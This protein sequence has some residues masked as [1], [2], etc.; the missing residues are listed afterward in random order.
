MD[1][2]GIS[3][4]SPGKKA[5]A[6]LFFLLFLAAGDYVLAAQPSHGAAPA[7]V[8]KLI[9][10][11]VQDP[12]YIVK[13]KDGR[14]GGLNVEIWKSIARDLN[15]D[16]EFRETTFGESL[17]HLKEGTIDISIESYFLLAERQKQI[18]YSIP[19]GN[20]RLALATLPNKIP[21]PWWAAVMILFSWATLKSVILLCLILCFLGFLLWIVERK[22]NPDHFGGGP[23]KGIVAGI[24]W[25][26]ST[27]A[28]GVCFGVALKSLAARLLGLIWML[29]CAVALSALIASLAS[30]LF[31]S[32]TMAQAV[33]RE[34]LAHMR[35]GGIAESAESAVLKNVAGEYVLYPT[36]TAA[37]DAVRTGKIDGFLY[38]EITLHYYQAHQYRNKISVYPTKSLRFMF[39]FGLPVESPLLRDVNYALLKLMETPDWRFLLERYGL[40][41]DFEQT[42]TEEANKILHGRKEEN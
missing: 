7:Q 33:T 42:G 24:Y 25:V 32:R 34:S 8:K 11:V 26:G 35:V 38:D 5:L 30:A 1:C 23:I 18:D 27:M 9:V 6:I 40:G 39:A 2:K 4:E 12:P 16:Y 28:S 15:L 3:L 21:H 31:Q 41:Q 20:T 36:E 22:D 19:F 14:W 29:V 10:G 13:E 17:D 37:L